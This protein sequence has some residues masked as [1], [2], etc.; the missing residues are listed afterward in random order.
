MNT[1]QVKSFVTRYL[2]TLDCQI[3]E[4]S[5]AHLTVKLSP[6]ADKDLTNRPY[7]W[8]FVQRC[9]VEPE[10]MTMKWILDPS[11]PIP[12][13]PKK[14]PQPAAPENDSD[15]ILGRYFGFTPTPVYVHIP[16]DEVT[17]GSRRLE[18]LFNSVRNKG[19]YVQLFE[20]QGPLIP[21][22]GA[23]GSTPNPYESWLNVN[24][25]V[26]L[27]CDMKRSEI[28][29]LG[30]HLGTGEIREGFYGWVHDKK[31]TPRIPANIHMMRGKV[32]LN[33]ASL[34]LE[35]YLTKKLKQYDHT[36]ALEAHDR[37]EEEVLRIR[38]YYESLL[39]NAEQGDRSKIEDQWN[40]RKQELEWQY[41]PRMHAFVI[42]CGLFHLKSPTLH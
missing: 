25:K 3:I 8:D 16:T 32:S 26:E 12:E 2:E 31:L 39:Q 30:V 42:N 13:P 17:Y 1:E 33:R 7:Y 6:E 10:T 9:G 15:S 11:I 14:A 36:W 23:W 29:S 19:K 21:G 18:Q 34:F 40:H 28:H 37:L 35:E 38:S 27:A 20:D 41:M 22:S 4:K 5:P 24:F